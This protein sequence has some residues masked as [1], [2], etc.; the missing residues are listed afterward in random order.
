MKLDSCSGNWVTIGLGPST[1][2]ISGSTWIAGPDPKDAEE[3]IP[4][5]NVDGKAASIDGLTVFA[6]IDSLSPEVDK[7]LRGSEAKAG[8]VQVST[9]DIVTK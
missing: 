4:D 9:L 8:G 6:P 3:Y 7:R 2:T 1:S 5:C